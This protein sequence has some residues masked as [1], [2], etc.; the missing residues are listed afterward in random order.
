MPILAPLRKR[1]APR[2]PDV[3]QL[4][5]QELS[6]SPAA[7]HPVDISAISTPGISPQLALVEPEHVDVA[8]LE[9]PSTQRVRPDLLPIEF[10]IIDVLT[11]LDSPSAHGSLFI[12]DKQLVSGATREPRLSTVALGQRKVYDPIEP[13][14]LD[15]F[16]LLLPL[17]M[18][19]AATEFHDDLLFPS[20]L[21]PFQRTGVKW[22]FENESGLLADDMGLGKTVQSITAFRALVRRSLALQA[23]VVCPKS[24]LRTWMRELERWAP[25]LVAVR[26]DGNQAQRRLKWRALVGKCHVLVTTYETV[27]QDREFIR[28]RVFDLVVADE[29]Q[30]IKNANTA[31]SRAVRALSGKRRWALTGTPL[32]NSLDD[33]VSVF[34]FVR[35]GTFT[36]V[37]AKHIAAKTVRDRIRPYMLRRRKQEALPQ[38]PPKMVDT[39][40]LE[41]TPAQRTAYDDAEVSGVSQLKSNSNVTIQHVLALIQELK[42]ICNFAPNGDSSKIEFMLEDYLEQACSDSQKLLV[43]SQ[44][45]RTLERIKKE[46]H[47]YNPLL[48]S[49]KLSSAQR[50]QIETEFETNE[51]N[52]VLLLSLRAGGVGLNLAR[53]N[54]VLHFDRW[55]NPATE[56]QAEDRTHRIGQTRTV[57]VTRMICED[58][59]E[60]RIESLLEKKGA[61]FDEVIDDLA[62]VT[63]ERVM[64]EEELFGLFGL[65]PPRRSRAEN[66]STTTKPVADPPPSAHVIRPEQP[67]SN[68]LNLRHVLRSCVDYIWWADLHFAHRALEEIYEALD[69]ANVHQVRILSGPANVNDRAT[70][71]FKRFREEMQLRGVNAE[72]RVSE[73]FAHDRF[74][75][76][77]GQCYNV[78]P[79]NSLLQGSYSEILETP[80]RPPFEH[81]W[82]EATSIDDSSATRGS[83]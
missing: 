14:G 75:L 62:D 53:A 2:P 83:A 19:P 48:F 59:I 37:E 68:V 8:T 43:V 13:K 16:E 44:Y 17:L 26:V 78:P 82:D 35:P 21:F 50:E 31:T 39:K 52:K 3:V 67:F 40:W 34:A 73:R 24:V 41:L 58:T 33:V 4:P 38:L 20:A 47:A 46:V 71:D 61:L 76:G 9:T 56:R 64:S 63:P 11:G 7:A 27:R 42:Q 60:E 70:R 45:V 15:L 22:L 57:F 29:V 74:I 72:W 65:K 79:I 1:F 32:E 6:W 49:G 5:D 77:R 18:P 80:N 30:R 12:K 69:P 36:T 55:W 28:G 54:H 10:T 25:E 51:D 66:T 23:L 81:W